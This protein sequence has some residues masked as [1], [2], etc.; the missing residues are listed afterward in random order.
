MQMN[1]IWLGMLPR[2]LTLLSRSPNEPSSYAWGQAHPSPKAIYT[3]RKYLSRAHTFT[4]GYIRM[5]TVINRWVR[6][7]ASGV[8]EN[9]WQSVSSG[10]SY[11]PSDR[12]GRRAVRLVNYLYQRLI[13]NHVTPAGLGALGFAFF[14]HYATPPGFCADR[15]DSHIP[16]IMSSLRY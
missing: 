3:I 12:Y 5:Y 8:S 16:F 1:W 7:C 13:W 10:W 14:Y 6:P 2:V 4:N 9:A 15:G 11:F